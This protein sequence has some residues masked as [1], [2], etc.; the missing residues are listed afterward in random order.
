MILLLAPCI[1]LNLNL[2]SLRRLLRPI[3]RVPVCPVVTK[4]P[5]S[6]PYSSAY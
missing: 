3:L 5:C 1:D 6:S 2:G 4:K